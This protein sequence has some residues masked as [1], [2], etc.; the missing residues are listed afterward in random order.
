MAEGQLRMG[1]FLKRIDTT[2]R[3]RKTY[4]KGI[5]FGMKAGGFRTEN[6]ERCVF[7]SAPGG[8]WCK[9]STL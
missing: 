3:G 6:Q 4:A 2:L 8:H 1:A 9:D 7:P 5:G